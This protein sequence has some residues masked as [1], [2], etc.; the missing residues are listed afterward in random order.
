[1][2]K[3]RINKLIQVIRK[4][5][6]FDGLGPTQIQLVLGACGPRRLEEGEVVCAAD[7]PGDEMYILL[8]GEAAVYA[9]DESEVAKIQPVATIGEM[10]IVTKQPRTST[11]KATQASNVLVLK[12]LSLDMALK[13]DAEAQAKI[14]RNVVEIL[15]GKM[16][17]DTARMREYQR[18]LLTSQ[19]AVVQLQRRLELALSL[20]AK[21]SGTDVEAAK[22]RIDEQLASAGDR[23]VLVVDDEEPIRRLLVEMLGDYDVI[24]AKDGSE[25]LETAMETKPDLVI[26]DIRMPDMDGYTLLMK[27]REFHPDLPVLALSGFVRDDDIKEY[28]FDGF[29]AKPMQAEEFKST[30]AAALASR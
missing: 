15:A 21:E 8:S 28:D 4:I 7:T 19:D 9:P 14:L 1:M 3:E 12:K 2:S 13:R 22:T 17:S 20:L 23:R 25:A 5:P 16:N 6:L 29:V 24:T 27:L 26:T 11:V 18:E 10:S 30:V